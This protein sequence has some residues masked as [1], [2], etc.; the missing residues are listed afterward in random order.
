M[1]SKEVIEYQ[2]TKNDRQADFQLIDNNQEAQKLDYEFFKNFPS[3][4]TQKSYR[5]DIKQFLK[6]LATNFPIVQNIAQTEKFHLV[7]YRNWLEDQAHFA[8][9]SINR[10]LAAVSSYFDFLCEKGF[11]EHNPCENIRRP[12]QEVVT[13]TN[14]LSD[15]EVRELFRVVDEKASPLHRAIIYLFFS[16]GI[17]KSELINLKLKDYKSIDGHKIIN[18]KA[19]GGKY[20]QKVIH[21]T[22]DEVLQEYLSW[23]HNSGKDLE[24]DDWIFRP[25]KNPSG[26]HASLDKTLRPKSV[27]YIVAKYAKMAGISKRISPHSARATYIGSALENGEDLFRVSQDVGHASV[28]TTQ[29]YNKRRAKLKESPAYNLAFLDKKIA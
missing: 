22:C 9:K 18:I 20:L 6:F 24:D 11:V 10:K 16:T 13:E 23:M 27:D 26:H 29:E 4:H 3:L 5:N 2:I 21:P 17:R 28:K 19:K 14:D 1:R 25:T 12:R 7:A 15:Y 8:P